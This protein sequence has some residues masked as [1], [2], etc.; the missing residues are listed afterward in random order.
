MAI[1]Q[2]IE[3][4]L[5][6][7]DEAANQQVL[8]LVVGE[9]S[10]L[11]HARWRRYQ[12]EATQWAKDA[13]GIDPDATAEFSED[14]RDRRER[15]YRRAAM[16]GA[17]K[18]VEIGTLDAERDEATGWQPAELPS[19]WQGVDGFIDNMPWQL[20]DTWMVVAADCNPGV[21]FRLTEPEEKKRNA[22][23]LRVQKSTKSLTIS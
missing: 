11:M 22:G 6:T 5:P 10:T 20:F 23:Q 19:E 18:R 8:R 4:V 9:M 2:I 13:L 17:L 3:Y 7:E 21:F 14:A 1:E 16:L 12:R 15:A